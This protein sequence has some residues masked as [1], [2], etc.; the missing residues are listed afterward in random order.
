MAVLAGFSAVA[1]VGQAIGAR[2]WHLGGLTV[3]R[4]GAAMAMLVATVGASVFRFSVRHLEGDPRRGRF[5][6]WLAFT[7]GSAGLLMLATDLIPLFIAWSLTSFGLHRLLT[8]YPDRA[9]AVRPARKKFLISRIGD[10]ALIGAI[11]T[12]VQAW[13]TTDLLEIDRAPAPADATAAH[14]AAVL[15]VIA[16]LTKSAQFPFHSWLPETMEAPTPVSAMMHAGVINAGGALLIRTSPIVGQSEAALLI[17]SAIG[18]STLAIGM[19]AMWAQA[20]AKRTLAWS[21]VAQMGFLMI[22]CGLGAFPAAMLHILGHGWYK[23]RAFLTIGELPAPGPKLDPSRSPMAALIGT[24]AAVPAMMIAARVTGFAPGESPGEWAMA[25]ILAMAIGQGWGVAIGRSWRPG[26]VV[27]AAIATPASA[28]LAFALYRGADL[29]LAPVLGES[30]PIESS[31]AIVAATIPVATFA[32]LIVVRAM[33]PALGRTAAGRAFYVHALN[34]FYFGAIADRLVDR[35]ARIFG[36][37]EVQ[38]A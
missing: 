16:A 12:T 28:I 19:L 17:L 25:A 32:A 37:R 36:L 30:R 26:W 34:G 27:S 24:A 10:A 1:V 14:A 31:T 3:D 5:L 18:S 35:V 29:Y 22:E 21:T 23:A 15:I 38:G 7:V 6:G 2:P 4:L 9:E 13:G 11:A 20:K 33:F 8:H